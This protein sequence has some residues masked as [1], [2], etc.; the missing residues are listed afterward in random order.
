MFEQY[1]QYLDAAYIQAAM[2]HAV[3][4]QLEDGTYYGSIPGFQGVWADERT[5]V[6]TQV[7]LQSALE[8]WLL[9]GI[10]KR[11]DLPEVDGLSLRYPK[12]SV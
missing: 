3:Y 5:L 7:E 1:E 10:S 8:D 12:A 6:E 2:G 9:I 4:E 11:A